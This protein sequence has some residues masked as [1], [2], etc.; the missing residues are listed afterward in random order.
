MT[1]LTNVGFDLSQ[2]FDL[3]DKIL[4]LLGF[5]DEKHAR[6]LKIE[7]LDIFNLDIDTA[8]TIGVKACPQPFEQGRV[9]T[10]MRFK[11][12]HQLG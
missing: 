7:E 4:S 11:T 8:R 1:R 5:V 10:D 2:D 9:S 6:N 12:L 3:K